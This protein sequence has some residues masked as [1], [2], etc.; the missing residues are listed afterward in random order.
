M[1]NINQ[2]DKDLQLPVEESSQEDVDNDA[3]KY[4]QVTPV[5]SLTRKVRVH[6]HNNYSYMCMYIIMCIIT[7]IT[8][9][10][11][12]DWTLKAYHPYVCACFRYIIFES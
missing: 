7:H 1:P 8:C 6:V 5:S 9:K 11:Y 2:V 3:E 12:R 4:V 10:Q